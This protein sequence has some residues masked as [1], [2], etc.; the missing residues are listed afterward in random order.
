MFEKII[1]IISR[2]LAAIVMFFL[3]DG[4]YLNQKGFQWLDGRIVLVKAAQASEAEKQAVDTSAFS[5]EE[6]HVLGSKDAPVA[7]Y[8][9]SSLGCTHCAD[10]HLGLLPRL[11]KDFV[12][13][14]KVKV[15]FVDFPIDKK[16]MQAAMLARCM[17][18]DKYFDFLSMLF[19]KQLTWGMS[20]KTEK[21]LSGY[22]E[23]E[24][25]SAEEAAACMKDDAAAAEIMY[26]RQ[27]A[28]EKLGLQATPSFLVRDAGGDVLFTGVPDYDKLSELLNKK[29]AD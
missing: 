9:F 16:S 7:V 18:E 2:S 5:V 8:E 17:P 3:A 15:V 22:A 12:D 11:K 28:M 4:F 26:N 1:K 21:L 29:L 13:G 14:G 6:Q 24:G 25:L 10:F 27:Q 23:M 19:K 20:F